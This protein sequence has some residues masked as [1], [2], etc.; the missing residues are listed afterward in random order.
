MKRFRRLLVRWEKKPKKSMEHS[1]RL[2]PTNDKCHHPPIV[3][4]NDWG[5]MT[6]FALRLP[7]GAR[8]L[9][10]SGVEAVEEV[11]RGDHKDQSRESLLVVVASGLLPDRIGDRVGTVSKPGDGL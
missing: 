11:G 8:H 7:V 6:G 9:P 1:L 4:A 5:V 10:G 2:S 3:C